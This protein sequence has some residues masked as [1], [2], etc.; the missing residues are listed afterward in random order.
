MMSHE[1]EAQI[2]IVRERAQNWAITAGVDKDTWY[3]YFN[4]F[5]CY[6]NPLTI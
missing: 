6:D 4:N 5:Y 1:L 2:K 3:S